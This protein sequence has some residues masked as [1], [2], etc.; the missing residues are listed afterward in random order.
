MVSKCCRE[1]NSELACTPPF[2]SFLLKSFTSAFFPVPVVQQCHLDD[3]ELID[4]VYEAQGER[5]EE[6][7][8]QRPRTNTRGD[9]TAAAVAQACSQL[10]L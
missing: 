9:G 6:Q 1:K 5:H 8:Y 10:E 2:S 7:P 4:R 3:E